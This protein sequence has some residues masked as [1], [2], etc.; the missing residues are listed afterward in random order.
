MSF[1]D[2]SQRAR[3]RRRLLLDGAAGFGAVALAGLLAEEAA[4]AAGTGWRDPLAA[5]VAHFPARAKRIVFLF[6]KGGPSQVDTFD[7]KPLLERD[8]GKPFPF[9]KPRVQFAQTG[10]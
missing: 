2:P 7:Y 9:T 8:H 5:R 3:S 10:N 4:A 6:M 1:C